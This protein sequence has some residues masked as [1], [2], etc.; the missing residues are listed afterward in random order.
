MHNL[1]VYYKLPVAQRAAALAP[2]RQ[3]LEAGRAWS[4]RVALLAR[5]TPDN[6]MAT[7]MEVYE[8]V[9]DIPGLEAALAEAVQASGL[10]PLL[11]APRRSEVFVDIPADPP[12]WES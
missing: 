12:G 6:G 2:A 4:A 8:D 1:Y 5:P 11:P 9:S 10:A 7:W 3:V